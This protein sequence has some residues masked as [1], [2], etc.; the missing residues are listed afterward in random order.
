MDSYTALMRADEVKTFPTLEMPAPK[1][2]ALPGRGQKVFVKLIQ[3]SSCVFT[4]RFYV[5]MPVGNGK[6][7]GFPRPF[8]NQK[9]HY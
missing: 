8:K 6:Q 1:I 3:F 5:F 9:V 7:V 2:R 4:T